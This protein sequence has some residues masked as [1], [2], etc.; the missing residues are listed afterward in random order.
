MKKKIAVIDGQGG[1]MGRI[2]IERLRESLSD[3]IE[4]LALGTNALATSAM[5][6]AGADHGASGE[7]AIMINS[8]KADIITGSLGIISANSFMGEL[9]PA[10]AAAI[11]ASGAV[12]VL[13][14]MNR[15]NLMV[16]GV[17]ESTIQ[18]YVEDAITIIGGLL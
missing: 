3:Q 12:K 10:M 13:V 6:K 15:C 1:G 17:R 16:A 14:P 4:I 5:I 11:S 2:L 7:N 18:A 8:V 9:T